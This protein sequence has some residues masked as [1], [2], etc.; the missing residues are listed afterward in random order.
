MSFSKPIFNFHRNI[1]WHGF[2]RNPNAIHIL[3]KRLNKVFW[4]M[5]SENPN[6][7]YL[8]EKNIDKISWSWLLLNPN[9]IHL[10][11][12]NMDKI[13]W[14]M[15]SQNPNAI[16]LLEQNVDKIEYWLSSNPNAIHLLAPLNHEQMRIDNKE[17]FQELV[18]FVCHPN[19]QMKCASR[20]NMDL[21]EYQYLLMECNLF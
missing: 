19:W 2:S 1:N 9:A 5:L 16:H 4:G 18:Q 7:I 8:L 3:E 10:F 21:D 14:A 20:L 12:Q 17:F 13:N 11:E 6:A 15:L